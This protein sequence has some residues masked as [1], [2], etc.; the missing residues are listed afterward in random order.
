MQIAAFIARSRDLHLVLLL[1]DIFYSSF[2]FS[3]QVSISDLRDYLLKQLLNFDSLTIPSP[4]E[5][6]KVDLG[7]FVDKEECDIDD[8]SDVVP[9]SSRTGPKLENTSLLYSSPPVKLFKLF[10]TDDFVTKMAEQ[11]NFHAVQ[12]G[13][14]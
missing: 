6:R 13:A 14:P 10:I 11:T 4:D 9:Y 7:T 8:E 5:E 12:R 2:V 1:P 3:L